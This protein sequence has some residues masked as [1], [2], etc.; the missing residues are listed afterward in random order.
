MALDV[1]AKRIYDPPDGGDGYPASLSTTSGHAASLASAPSSTSGRASSHPATSYANG[2][3][4]S[5]S[6][7]DEF[8]SR[9]R[10]ELAAQSERLEEL[11]RAAASGPLTILYAARD[12]EHNNAVVLSE[13]LRDG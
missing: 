2:S 3:T 8:R 4:T 5:P 1:R 6:A 9:Y 12:R 7:F 13:L 11:R 10:D